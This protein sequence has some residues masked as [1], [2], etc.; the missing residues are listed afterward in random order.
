MKTRD[1]VLTCS[2]GAEWM[3]ANMPDDA[4]DRVAKIWESEHSGPGHEPCDEATA[5]RAR[6]R[7]EDI[8]TG[9]IRE[10]SK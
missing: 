5:R 2:C 1:L 3:F 6:L 4:A 8:W 10:A 7:A 9:S